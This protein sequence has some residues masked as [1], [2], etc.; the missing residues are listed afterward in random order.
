MG[1]RGSHAYLASPEVVAASALSGKISGTGVY[2][3]PENLNGIEFGYGTGSPASPLSELESAVEQLDSLIDR[4]KSS[5]LQGDDGAKETT[6]ILPGFPKKISGEILFCDADNLDTDNIYAAK[7]T[8]QDDI[9]KEGMA[10]VCMSNY[11]P[12]FGS[13][14]KPNDILV[15]GY[16]FGCGS[17]R[18][19]AAT[20]IL[21]RQIPL[22]VA[23]SFSSIFARNSINNALLGMEVPRLIKRLRAA[24]PSS[25]KVPTRRTGWTLTWDIS[26]GTIKV[27]EGEDGECWEE[28]VGQFPEN[29]QEI[30]AKGGLT[31]WVKH[32]I[33]KVAV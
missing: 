23:G 32:E 5:V 22:V 15:S 28:K 9:T 31:E 18:E 8:Y 33:A 17:S 12:D 4:V 21:A 30:I 24:F 1:S 25:E 3:A 13:V 14:A 6:R 2:K 7:W 19:Q 10:E 16:N 29:L 26:R 11:D 20:A 27:Q